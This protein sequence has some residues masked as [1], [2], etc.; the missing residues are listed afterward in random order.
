MERKTILIAD[1]D[2]HDAEL[3]KRVFKQSRI[4]NSLQTVSDGEEAIAYLN[5]DG[6]FGERIAYPYPVLLLLDLKM[7]KK[8]GFDV[9]EWLHGR[10]K[11]KDLAVV[12]LT[13]VTDTKDINRAYKLGANSFLMKP[14]ETEDLM[15][16]FNGLKNLSVETED[17]GYHVSYL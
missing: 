11:A 9:L 1:D 10:P 2:R 16:L 5:G 4:L 7:P 13:V 14:L 12:V 6:K 17:A 8:S 15:N 3:I